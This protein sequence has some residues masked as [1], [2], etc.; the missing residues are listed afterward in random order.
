[1]NITGAIFDCDGTLLDSMGMWAQ[2]NVWMAE[3]HGAAAPPLDRIESLSLRDTCAFYHEELAMGLGREALYE[4]PC[5]L[6]RDA[7]VHEV[8]P[9]DGALEFLRE[10]S[11]AGVPL[12][13]A[14]STPSRELRCALAA[15]G[16]LDLFQ[17][18]VSTEDV[19]GRDKEFPDV[20]L[21]AARRIGSDLDTY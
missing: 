3:R 8:V 2:A 11:Q 9:L 21:E 10:L 14:S 4:E 19:G 12:A 13:V 6:V 7:F 16:M 17:A 1:M 15:H 20:Y 5:A 18:V